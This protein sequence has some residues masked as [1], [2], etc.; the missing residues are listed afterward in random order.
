MAPVTRSASEPP[1]DAQSPWVQLRAATL[2]P[3]IYK[4]MI[5]QA[6]PAARPGDVVTLYDKSGR[7]FGRGLYN[8]R[9]QIVVRLLSA[10]AAPVD[11]AFWRARLEQA[12][13]LRR[14]LRLDDVTDAYRLVHSEGDGLSGLIVERYADCL[15]FEL[16]S[17]GMFQR[18]HDF[19][20]LLITLLGPPRV[21]D[22]PARHPAA[23]RSVMRA[24]ARVERLE[25]FR[26]PSAAHQLPASDDGR[27]V[28]REHGV[29]YRVD[30]KHG[31]KTG[32]F[33]DQRDNRRRLAALCHDATVLDLCCY[34]GGFALC[35]LKLGG[36]RAV[37][38][39]DL[40]ETA[41]AAARE[42]ANL[43]QVRVD[44]VYADAFTYMRQMLA[45]GRQFDVVVLDPPKLATYRVEV[46]D[47]LRKYHDLNHLALQCVRLGGVL[48]TCSCTGLVSPTAFL[49]A[50]QRAAHHAGR[51]LQLFE[52]T[53]A[54]PDHPIMLNC[55]E[56]AYLKAL[57]FRVLG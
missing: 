37:T 36:A 46:D 34:T 15:V 57:W 55:P 31:H 53:S 25:G 19:R 10:D 29:R 27:V 45:L 14:Q 49:D 20:D 6:D 32:F 30:V 42:N 17:L 26:V 24:D 16:F 28:I 40:D 39:V 3:F 18:C 21:L 9:S 33:C 8:P 48:L 2:H 23:W 35:A 5:R 7:F 54:G 41:I 38:G 56:S 44:F 50:V 47:A 51:R 43:N 12:L 1:P 11:T 22:R 13:A 4:K 52:R